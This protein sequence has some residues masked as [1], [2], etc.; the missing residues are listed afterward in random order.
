M[1]RN[2]Y[3]CCKD[4]DSQ[5]KINEM[6]HVVIICLSIFFLFSCTTSTEETLTQIDKVEV[7]K[8][9]PKVVTKM[10]NKLD[11]EL[12]Y[13]ISISYP[14]VVRKS[15]KRFNSTCEKIARD[16]EKDFIS[17][18]QGFEPISRREL[19]SKYKVTFN[20]A[21]YMSLVLK[22][23]KAVPATSTLLNDYKTVNWDLNKDEP[24]QVAD[25][26]FKDN[27]SEKITEQ[28]RK[29]LP[30][31][32]EITIELL[33]R[34]NFL[35]RKDALEVFNVGVSGGVDCYDYST[36]I[37]WSELKGVLSEKGKEILMIK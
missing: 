30:E 34:N 28:I 21:D 5:F 11:K 17:L 7:T 8:E 22:S 33:D 12:N 1:N 24:I 19:N 9:S 35:I 6:K 15:N 10:I 29:E 25:L 16:L 4:L 26:F 23:S 37:K 3:L 31:G 36:V 2:S 20:N 32:C 18:I 13:R 27:W 14:Q